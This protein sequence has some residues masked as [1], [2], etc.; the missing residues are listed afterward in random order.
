MHLAY[1]INQYPKVSHSF[2]RREIL[3]LEKQG[4]QVTR[5]A[6]RGWDAEL[7]D[8]ED[9]SE[10]DKTQF[11][12][13]RGL[14]PMM[15]TMAGLFLENP[16]RFLKTTMLA[17]RL[18]LRADRSWPYH[19]I[20]LMEA[21]QVV[22]ITRAKNV[23]H[24]HAHFGTNS[25]EVVMLSYLLGGP[26]YSFTVH[27]PEEFDK[28]TFIHLRDKIRHSRFVAAISSYTRSQLYR[29]ADFEDWGKIHVVHC[30]LEE[31]FYSVPAVALPQR[32]RLVCVGRI[33]EQKGQLLLIQATYLVKEMGLDFELVLAG[34]GEMRAIVEQQIAKL[35]LQE[36]VKITGW[37]SGDQVREEILNASA[38]V[39]PSF[40][41]GLPVVI[42]E[43]LALKRPVLTTYVAG[44]PELVVHHENGW[45]FPA[46]DVYALRDAIVDFLNTPVD[47]L[48]AMGE[49]GF[50]RVI[51]R[52]AIDAEVQKLD[53]L[54][55]QG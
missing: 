37:I 18:G 52:H 8:E 45:L 4:H 48:N 17:L 30:G 23:A 49:A 34:D 55:Q 41:E 20:Y 6:L 39:L 12:L 21:C 13:N 35:G 43:A 22:A 11:I 38:L 47:K 51:Q 28:T 54:F 2:I 33:C 44:I 40:A 16:V 32:S 5:I 1:F 36:Q 27:G 10:R 15:K 29:W 14:L 3:A 53:K 26:A 46:G 50:T 42:M 9:V 31:S 25:A 7:V 19:L 24:V